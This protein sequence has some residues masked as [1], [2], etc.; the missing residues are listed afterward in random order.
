MRSG[1]EIIIAFTLKPAYCV[2]NTFGSHVFYPLFAKQLNEILAEHQCLI[3]PVLNFRLHIE[4]QLQGVWKEYEIFYCLVL[5]NRGHKT[6]WCNPL[7]SYRTKGPPSFPLGPPCTFWC[8]WF[9][10]SFSFNKT[11]AKSMSILRCIC[12]QILSFRHPN[13][14]KFFPVQIVHF[15]FGK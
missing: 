3:F 4:V 1:V 8:V 7:N 15:P 13:K 9:C 12:W 2:V 11:R 6:S 5:E 10:F 14:T